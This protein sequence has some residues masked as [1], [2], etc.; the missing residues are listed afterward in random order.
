MDRARMEAI[1]SKATVCRL[2]LADENGPYVV[3][4]SFG[5]ED[6]ILYF[7]GGARGRKVSMLRNNSNV[8]FEVDVDVEVMLSETGCGS[9]IRYRSVIGFGKARFIEGHAEKKRALNVIMRHYT[10]REFD[11]ADNDVRRATVF[12][13]EIE[14]MSGKQAGYD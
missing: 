1:L 3:P 10:G 5:Y 4:L 12:C 9:T 2:G 11:L 13:V 7:H 6:N 14:S 8:C